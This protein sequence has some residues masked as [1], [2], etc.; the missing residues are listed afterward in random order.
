MDLVSD[1]HAAG[2]PASSARSSLSWA[3]SGLVRNRT[4]SGTRAARHRAGS[5]VQRSGRYS[6]RSMNARP[7]GLAQARKTPSWQLSSLPAVPEY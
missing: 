4:R 5:S 1:H 6:S 3:S 7:F 2:T